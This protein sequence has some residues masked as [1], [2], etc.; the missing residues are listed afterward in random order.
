MILRLGGV[1][2]FRKQAFVERMGRCAGSGD[3]AVSQVHVVLPLGSGCWSR[4]CGRAKARVSV[5]LVRACL[6][7]STQFPSLRHWDPQE[8]PA[9]SAWILGAE[10]GLSLSS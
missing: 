10:H 6:K 3:A 8:D 7:P 9:P 2:Y 1:G 5:G 4:E